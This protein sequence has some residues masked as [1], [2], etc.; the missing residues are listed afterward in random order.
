MRRRNFIAGLAS[1]TAVW[2]LAARAQQPNRVQRIGVL[3]AYPESDHD[4]QSWVSAFR[5]E[6]RKLEWTEGVN[7]HID[8]RW[9]TADV[10]SIERRA[11]ELAAFRP[12]LI[13]TSSTPATAAMVQQTRT[14]PIIFVMVGD[15]VGSGFVESLSR[16][17][18]NLTGFTPIESSLGGKWMELLKEITPTVTRAAML[19]NPPTA[20]FAPYYLNPFKV[21]AE[22]FGVE[23][24]VA[25]V[26]DESELESVVATQARQPNSGLIVMPDAFTIS[27]RA[28]I[29]MLAARY[30]IPAI[31]SFRFFAEAGGLMSYGVNPLGEFQRAAS[32]AD[33]IL[34]GAKPSELPVEA[35]IKFELVLNRKAATALGLTVPP[36]LL[37]RADDVIE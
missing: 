10:E 5:E 30:R 7:V 25:P 26:E 22:S 2:S 36:S 34:K 4:A 6:L 19:F 21:A 15:P 12:D 9:A 13:L 32:Y 33:R 37:T 17:G 14:I 18:G 29:A 11:K 28:G 20:P 8:V 24:I 31:Y 35:P 3:L 1:T 27:H 23:A 16:P